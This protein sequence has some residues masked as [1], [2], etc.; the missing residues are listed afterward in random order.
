[1][2]YVKIY[3]KKYESHFEFSRVPLEISEEEKREMRSDYLYEYVTFNE[4]QTC[5]GDFCYEI[6][7]KRFSDE[8]IAEALYMN[9]TE[10]VEEA[11]K[12]EFFNLGEELES[13]NPEDDLCEYDRYSG[14]LYLKAEYCTENS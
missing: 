3:E 14:R 8:D 13:Y 5:S 1:M 7:V 11:L 2:L 10:D 4:Q 6:D 12:F 9:D